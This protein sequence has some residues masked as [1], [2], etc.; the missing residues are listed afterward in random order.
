M[1]VLKKAQVPEKK[2]EPTTTP[3]EPSRI[4]LK[5]V[6]P[7]SPATDVKVPLV[8]PAPTKPAEVNKS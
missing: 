2:E 7:S 4:S 6:K 1:F 8:R 5:P 3:A